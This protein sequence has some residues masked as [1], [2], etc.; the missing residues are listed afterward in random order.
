MIVINLLLRKS[1]P[2]PKALLWFALSGFVGYFLNKLGFSMSAVIIGIILGSMA[3]QNFVGSLIMSDGSSTIRF[4]NPK[5]FRSE[6]EI[7]VRMDGREI[8]HLNE[9]EYIGGE[10]WANVYGTDYIVIIDPA[11]GNV[12][13]LVD[14]SGILSPSLRKPSTDVL[15]GIALDPA[16]GDI[17]ITGKYWPKLFRVKPASK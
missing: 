4:R 2:K 15:N 5:S 7:T 11:S 3:E 16:T 14:C 10:I 12:R 9:L 17:Y 13:E 6:R 1:F 8:R